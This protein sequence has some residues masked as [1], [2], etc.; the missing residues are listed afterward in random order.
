MAPTAICSITT[1]WRG[2]LGRGQRRRLRVAGAIAAWLLLL[3]LA[4]GEEVWRLAMLGRSSLRY[5]LFEGTC[6]VG[7]FGHARGSGERTARAR[8]ASAQAARAWAWAR[9][10]A[11]KNRTLSRRWVGARGTSFL[12]L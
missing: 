5:D 8:G 3:K 2:N 9:G 7:K 12:R 11:C 6:L 1:S 4:L 10:I